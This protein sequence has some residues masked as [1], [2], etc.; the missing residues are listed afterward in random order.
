M[1]SCGG[2]PFRSLSVYV[3]DGVLAEMD[4]FF[5]LAQLIH[6]FGTKLSTERPELLSRPELSKSYSCK[7]ARY[8]DMINTSV[9]HLEKMARSYFLENVVREVIALGVK[10][11]NQGWGN[12]RLS[13]RFFAWLDLKQNDYAVRHALR[14]KESKLK[15][16]ITMQ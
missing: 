16:E 4:H 1:Q 13:K 3:R 9:L 7:K 2:T 12:E 14:E 6:E 5:P 11:R 10:G 15:R 8:T